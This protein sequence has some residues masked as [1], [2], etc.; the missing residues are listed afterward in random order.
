M[1]QNL[2]VLKK[3][4]FPLDEINI[5]IKDPNELFELKNTF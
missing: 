2:I 3:F 4:Y 5:F 1:E